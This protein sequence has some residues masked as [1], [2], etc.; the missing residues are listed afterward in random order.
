MKLEIIKD[1]IN[2]F[3]DNY[4]KVGDSYVYN[5]GSIIRLI[6]DVL[7]I[8]AI[9]VF[10]YYYLAKYTGKKIVIF[11]VVGLLVGYIL[12]VLF[13][14]HL[15]YKIYPYLVLIY[16][17]VWLI[18]YA[19]SIRTMFGEMTKP[20]NTKTFLSNV[21]AQEELISTL[22]KTADYLSARKIGAIITIEK[23]DSLN[24]YI[25]K[26]TRLDSETSF[27]LL[28]T[29]FMPG[30]ALHDGAVI[31]RGKHIMSAGSFY[32]PTD[33][34]DIPKNFGS[35]HR[36]AIGIS[37][38][39]DAFTLVVSEETGHIAVTMVRNLTPD[40]SLE[41]LRVLLKQNIIVE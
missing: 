13:D 37:E 17:I 20:R 26:G 38:I 24:T 23:E 4:F 39:T 40:V 11:S 31:I 22:I 5:S 12:V 15:M 6:V 34:N 8:L 41:S 16:V 27:E 9:A 3:K 14:L 7:L 30:T 10:A 2:Y 35:R 29:I 18:Y 33:K 28:T 36:A 25:N 19:P 32:P 1:I 21:E